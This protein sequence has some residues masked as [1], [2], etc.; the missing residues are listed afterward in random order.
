MKKSWAKEKVKTLS[1]F[2]TWTQLNRIWRAKYFSR[3]AILCVIIHIFWA[4]IATFLQSGMEWLAY[5][6]LILL[7]IYSVF[8]S[9]CLCNKRLHDRWFSWWWQLLLLIPFV[10]FIILI[11]LWFVPGDKIGNKYGEPSKTKKWE[12]FLC[13]VIPLLYFVLI[14]I[15]TF[16]PRM[17]ASSDR[18]RDVARKLDISQIQNAIV[19]YQQAFWEWP[20]IDKAKN[21]VSISNGLSQLVQVFPYVW[22]STIPRDPNDSS[23]NYWLWSRNSAGKIENLWQYLYL[24]TQK[25]WIKNGWFVL[26]AK[27]ETEWWSNW[28]VCKNG[29]WL[30]KWYITNGTDLNEIQFCRALTKW[31]SCSASMCT[32][33]DKDELRYILAY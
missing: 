11:C 6:L 27:T 17:Q 29:N 1:N 3:N 26:M 31:K 18:A 28:V 10:D 22:I 15:A 33:S 16:L 21:W 8:C 12:K 25:N 2:V 4:T 7:V 24:V 19:T 9:I 23:D 13:V 20:D 32:Y 14:L 30:D 5:F